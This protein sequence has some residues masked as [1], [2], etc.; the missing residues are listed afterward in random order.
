MP[1]CYTSVTK[2]EMTY[3]DGGGSISATL[4]FGLTENLRKCIHN[5]GCGILVSLAT[6]AVCAALG[7]TGVGAVLIPTAIGAIAGIASSIIAD[8][9]IKGNKWYTKKV[10]KWAPF[11]NWNI[12]INLGMMGW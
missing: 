4:K 10:S 11:I 2:E 3:V 1:S 7:A 6:G 5:T 12:N 9:R 8:K